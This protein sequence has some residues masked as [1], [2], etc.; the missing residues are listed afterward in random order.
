M[1]VYLHASSLKSTG[2]YFVQDICNG[3]LN[4]ENV[5]T[6]IVVLFQFSCRVC[7]L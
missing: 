2:F 6:Q 7:I 5:I 3:V 1:V 4:L